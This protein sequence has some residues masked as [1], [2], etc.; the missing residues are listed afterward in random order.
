MK[1]ALAAQDNKESAY[2]AGDPDLIP[3]L[4]RSSGEGNGNPLQY[5]CLENLMD[6][7]AFVGYNPWGRKESDT[8]ERLHFPKVN[9]VLSLSRLFNGYYCSS[10]VCFNFWLGLCLLGSNSL[11]QGSLTMAQGIRPISGVA[12]VPTVLWN[13]QQGTSIPLG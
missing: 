2:N 4:G 1:D 7:G 5:S 13:N 8:T 12:Q 10:L 3:G 6:G 9:L 11:K